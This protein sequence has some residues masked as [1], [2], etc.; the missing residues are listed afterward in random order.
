MHLV[1]SA[2]PEPPVL[3][4]ARLIP[5]L[6]QPAGM[7]EI[8]GFYLRNRDHL[9]GTM[10]TAPE[11]FYTADYWQARI[12]AQQREFREGRS[13]R[14]FLFARADPAREIGISTLSEIQHGPPQAC[15]P[16]FAMEGYARD[17]PPLGGQWR[18]HIPASLID[19][20]W[21]AT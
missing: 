11:G 15:R 6:A 3:T 4:T 5:Q 7:P 12:E 17:C 10:P 8:L 9:A 21:R 14:L 2:L 16:G 1:Q 19:R 13:A 20:N 18:D